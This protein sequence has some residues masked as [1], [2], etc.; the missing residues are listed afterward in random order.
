MVH[1]GKS[2]V[3]HSTIPIEAPLQHLYKK[4]KYLIIKI[5]KKHRIHIVM[6]GN[7]K[8]EKNFTS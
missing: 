6:V 3:Q 8:N 1:P 7:K 2:I 4:S 5:L